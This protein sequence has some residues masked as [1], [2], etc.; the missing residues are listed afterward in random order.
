MA[1]WAISFLLASLLMSAI[2]LII[3]LCNKLFPK[4]CPA[5]LRYAIWLVVLIGLIIP[6][7]PVIGG[8]LFTVQAPESVQLQSDNVKTVPVENAVTG[9]EAV[10]DNTDTG[11][12]E[13]SSAG[14]PVLP[15]AVFIWICGIVAIMILAYHIWRYALFARMIKRWGVSGE[16]ERILYVFES[17][18]EDLGLS[19]EKIDLKI[20]NFVSSSMLTGFLHPVILL[21]DKPFDEDE[22]QLIFR[23]ELIHYKRHDLFIKLLIVIVTCIHWFN[24]IVYWMCAAMQT[25]GEASCDETVLQNTDMENRRFYGEVIIG[26]I[27]NQRIPKTALSTCFYA[28]K[29]NMKRRLDSRAKKRRK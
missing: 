13:S 15:A 18:K 20:C 5:K 14:S 29:S 7:R 25:D 3:M 11:M 23:H 4:A 12:T 19:K 27:G 21:P 26:M 8:G 6:F 22:L 10:Q 28:G 16:D 1:N 9:T 24:P 17:A 2:I